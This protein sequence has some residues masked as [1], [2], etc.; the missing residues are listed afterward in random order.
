MLLTTVWLRLTHTQ[1]ACPSCSVLRTWCK[2]ALAAC[3]GSAPWSHPPDVHH[4][5]ATRVVL[6]LLVFTGGTSAMK[7]HPVSLLIWSL[8]SPRHTEIRISLGV[9]QVPLSDS[10][11]A[12]SSGHRVVRAILQLSFTPST[13]LLLLLLRLQVRQW[14]RLHTKGWSTKSWDDVWMQIFVQ[15]FVS[16]KPELISQ[17]LVAGGIGWSIKLWSYVLERPTAVRPGVLDFVCVWW[18]EP[19]HLR[20]KRARLDNHR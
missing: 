14:G 4:I 2:T 18:V 15:R 1:S 8:P 13:A 12:A 20:Y 19:Y 16:G 10:I 6:V 9:G 17:A 11:S 3:G 5:V 7:R